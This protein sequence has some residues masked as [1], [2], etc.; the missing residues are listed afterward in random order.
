MQRQKS[1]SKPQDGE[2]RRRRRSEDEGRSV[3]FSPDARLCVSL[4]C[5]SLCLFI[6]WLHVQQSATLAEI[7]QKYERL[8]GLEETLSAVSLE[9]VSQTEASELREG[10]SRLR[11]QQRQLQL[12]LSALSRAVEDAEQQL[13][14]GLASRLSSIRT[15]VRRMAGLEGEAAL[16]RNQTQALEEKVSQTEKMMVRRVGD[17][18][19]ASIDRVSALRSTADRSVQRLEQASA[20][21]QQLSDAHRQLD[22]RILGLESGQAKLLK[23]AAFANDLKPKVFSLRQDLA[24]IQPTL[25]DLTL[26]I[27][28]LAEDLMSREE[29]RRSV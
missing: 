14:S 21:A 27:G 11:G 2:K 9:C 5:L 20:L 7:S 8:R 29:E 6:T 1:A 18:L 28:L 23:T 12:D 19:A 3:A 10:L 15:D 24:G 17:L 22:Q 26:R 16:L 25:D 13:S 4:L